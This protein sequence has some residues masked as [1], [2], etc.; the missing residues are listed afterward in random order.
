[1]T[2][3]DKASSAKTTAPIPETMADK[4][5]SHKTG[6][7]KGKQKTVKFGKVVE[8][9]DNVTTKII[10]SKFLKFSGYS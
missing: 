5:T 10:R 2:S 9:H 7:R 1:M 3:H 4:P 8:V 6:R